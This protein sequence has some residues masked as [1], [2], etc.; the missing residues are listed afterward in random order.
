MH[1]LGAVAHKS[2]TCLCTDSKEAVLLP[3][4]QAAAALAANPADSAI[5]ERHLRS[6]Q[7]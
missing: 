1:R 2:S 4:W 6:Y 5:A 7:R 3:G